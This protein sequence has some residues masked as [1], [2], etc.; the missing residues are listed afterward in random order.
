MSGK[1]PVG[2]P[3]GKT[4]TV[5]HTPIA[6]AKDTEVISGIFFPN[7]VLVFLFLI[8]FKCFQRGSIHEMAHR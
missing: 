1:V 6:I 7:I 5:E 2:I 3:F 8:F 4:R